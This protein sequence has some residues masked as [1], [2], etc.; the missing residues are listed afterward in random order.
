MGINDSLILFTGAAELPV[1]AGS[2]LL[3][4]CPADPGGAAAPRDAVSRGAAG[5]TQRREGSWAVWGELPSPPGLLDD[6]GGTGRMQVDRLLADPKVRSVGLH[7]VGWWQ[8][9]GLLA[10]GASQIISPRLLLP[11]LMIR[12]LRGVVW[13]GTR[14]AW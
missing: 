9:V 11:Q 12:S 13:D 2:S 10:G 6:A 5:G 8:A 1:A 3:L 4:S 7:T 14:L